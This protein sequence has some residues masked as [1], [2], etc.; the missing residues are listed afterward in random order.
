MRR[1][2]RTEY[3]DASAICQMLDLDFVHD[4]N[5]QYIICL[6]RTPVLMY[7]SGSFA[8]VGAD[9]IHLSS[10]PF[11]SENI[12]FVEEK[13]L[14]DLIYRYAPGQVDLRYDGRM[15]T[16]KSP[17]ADILSVQCI[18]EE[19]GVRYEIVMAR[20]YAVNV[21]PLDSIR[22]AIEFKDV[23]IT[24]GLTSGF[25]D[26]NLPVRHSWS[27]DSSSL[28]I[29]SDYLIGNIHQ[30]GPDKGNTLT[31]RLSLLKNG[32]APRAW[33]QGKSVFD[34]IQD[35][36]DSWKIDKIVIDPGHGGKDPGAIGKS[37]VYEKDLVLALGLTLRKT[38]KS[39]FRLEVV[40]TRDDDFFVPLKERTSFANHVD[41]KLFISLHLNS[42]TSTRTRGAETY[43]LAPAKTKSAMKLALKENE[44]IKYE[45][46]KFDYVD[47]TEENYILLSMA[48]SQF[49][50]ESEEFAAL[51][52]EKVALRTGARDRGVDQAAFYV[53]I[54]ASMPAILFEA[55]FISNPDEAKKFGTE[56]YRQ[57]VA[58]GLCDAIEIFVNSSSS[59]ER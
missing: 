48:Q 40:M 42:I 20:N 21:I 59:S 30:M 6:P 35:A 1:E 17:E 45:E 34:E 10:P 37:G 8:M 55:G 27:Q 13:F 12:F 4:M 26:E 49:V 24:P 15:L 31:L 28:I 25:P 46:S 2:G 54:G 57:K 5:E 53:L 50:K 23:R 16:Y 47:L 18:E 11:E 52:Q 44:V 33:D 19:T 56:K 43:F 58:D 9:I 7:S 3:V 22:V 41:G 14:F 51:V 36:M 32:F 39:R 29:Q 38:I